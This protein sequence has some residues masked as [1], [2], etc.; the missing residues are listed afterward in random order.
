MKL[1][2]HGAA[3]M[4]TG[5]N[6]LLEV[7]NKKILIDC[8][9]FQGLPEISHKNYEPFPYDPKSIDFVLITHAHLDHV[10]RLPKL[11]TE[12]FS[13]K[14]LATAPT[15]DFAWLVLEDSQKILEEKAEREGVLPPFDHFDIARLMEL[16]RKAEYD[17]PIELFSGARAVF[18]EA[19]H[20][21]GSAVIEIEI[22]DNKT[23][24]VNK[25]TKIVFSGDLGNESM[26]ILRK[27]ALIKEAD[28][29]VVESTYGN[30]R[31][32]SLNKCHELIEDIAEQTIARNGVL[33]IP[34]FA[35]E[36]TQQ[37]LYQF[38]HLVENKKI[39]RVPIFIDS[40]LALRATEVYK[41]YARYY[42]KEATALLK[43]GD[44]FF[45]F[46]ELYLTPTV[47]ESKRINGMKPPKIII[48][49]S[50][51]SQG[52][53]ILHHEERYLSDPNNALLIVSYQAE[54]TLGRQLL[55]RQSEVEIL[56]NR[57]MVNARVEHINGYSAHADGKGLFDW[58]SQA[59]N[60]LKKV[61]VVHG[62]ERPAT[63]LAQEIQDRLGVVAEIPEMNAIYDL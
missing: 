40:P 13:G 59:K 25:K 63:A 33:M 35:L 47:A 4:V 49:G 24:S 6:H 48:A 42:D 62:E 27:P 31:H 26:P 3:R 32:Q 23:K 14:I 2:F 19:G 21:L 15:I 17:E 8:G 43:S 11:L 57:I 54:G 46:P 10:G 52:G 39:P 30:K 36:R 18:R 53:R 56:E 34:S 55:E 51:M 38:N 20:I 50:G 22:N 37:L 58:V 61:F 45:D 29:L 60:G 44:D 16:F 5:S 1:S 7:N 9:L 12:G 28:Y 41:K